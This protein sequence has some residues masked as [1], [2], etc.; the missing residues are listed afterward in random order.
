LIYY[1]IVLDRYYDTTW[2]DD[3][4]VGK[5]LVYIELE[6]WANAREQ[7]LIFKSK[8]PD[9]DLEYTVDRSMQKVSS[10]LED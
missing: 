7:V 9:S 5:A 1:E 6:E 8:F 3:A 2:A 10:N 4:L